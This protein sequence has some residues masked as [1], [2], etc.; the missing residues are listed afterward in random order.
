M[1][2]ALPWVLSLLFGW[3]MLYSP[4][5]LYLPGWYPDLWP[6][7][8]SGVLMGTLIT[9]I[10]FRVA[11]A[12]FPRGRDGATSDPAE[13]SPMVESRHT[14]DKTISTPTRLSL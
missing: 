3:Y 8:G 9:G 1:V 10:A 14:R 6:T 11:T 13:P 5:A 4:L 7:T 2:R 12:F